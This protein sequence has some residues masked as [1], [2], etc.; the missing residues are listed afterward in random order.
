MTVWWP[1]LVAS[2][3]NSKILCLTEYSILNTYCIYYCISTGGKHCT[4]H[5]QHCAAHCQRCAAHC[6]HCTAHCQ[7]ACRP[8]ELKVTFIA[9][10]DVMQCERYR[11]SEELAGCIFRYNN[12]SIGKLTFMVPRRLLNNTYCCWLANYVPPCEYVN[13]WLRRFVR[14]TSVGNYREGQ[15]VAWSQESL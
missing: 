1:K 9:F 7:P 6:Q 4:A 15:L 2:K 10:C 5:C 8:T 12:N 3:W 13:L 14:K 11:R